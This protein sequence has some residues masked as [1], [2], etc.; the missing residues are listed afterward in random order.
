MLCTCDEVNQ[1]LQKYM[2]LNLGIEG[3]MGIPLQLMGFKSVFSR[4][5]QNQKLV[6]G[7]NQ[8]NQI[9]EFNQTRAV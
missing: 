1:I 3:Y 4:D 6:C 2:I 7:Q 9:I 8:F 5:N